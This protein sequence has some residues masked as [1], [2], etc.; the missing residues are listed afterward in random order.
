MIVTESRDELE[1]LTR[2]LDS[3][4]DR[5]NQ[6]ISDIQQ[7]LTQIAGG[8][9]DVSSQGEYQ[10]DFTLIQQ[11]LRTIIQSMN[12]TILG[13][14]SAASRLSQMAEELNGQSNQLHH[15]SLEQNQS[16]EA[17]AG[18]VVHVQEQLA[19]VTQ[20]SSQTRA[21][22]EE[23]AQRVQEANQQ[24]DSLT[25]AMDN[26]SANAQEINMIAKAIEDV[27]FQTGILAINASIEAARA[28]TAG[29]GF[30][31]V[32]GEVKDLAA[33]SA[34]A[35]K[36]A[37]EVVSRTRSIIQTGVELTAQ[38]AESVQA[39]SGVSGQISAISD[40]LVTAVQGQKA[41]LSIIETRIGEITDIADR[42]LQNAGESEQASALLAREASALQAKVEQFTLKEEQ[43]T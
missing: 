4:V 10:G 2:T 13:F 19:S 17:L 39:I 34:E 27:A 3:T 12:E 29:R 31:V 42:N 24:M 11:S 40:Q 28:G 1:V 36:S 16:T 33:R 21:K 15:A 9:L 6:Y 26:I 32:A 30:A 5:M 25:S 20:S 37:T 18:E 38:T 7:V 22:T 23:I 8:N 43:E 41:A 14:R 35:A